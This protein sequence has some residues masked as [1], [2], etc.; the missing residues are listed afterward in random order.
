ME[1]R[2]VI[3]NDFYALDVNA[4]NALLFRSITP[5]AVGRERKN[6][7]KHKTCSYKYSVIF[8][9]QQLFICKRAFCSLYQI[10]RKK[11]DVIKA[12]LKSGKSVPSKDRR[13]THT[14]RPH[15]LGDA[16]EQAI[17]AHINTFPTEE[18]H[19]SRNSNPHKRYLAP[20]LN[21][22]LMYRLYIDECK[23]QNLGENFLVNKSSYA[24]I[25]L[26]KFNLS[27]SHPKSDTC[28]R[29]DAGN[30]NDEHKENVNLGFQL[31]SKDRENAS[32]DEKV[33][34]ITVDLQQTM[35]LPKLTTSKA[36]YLRQI[37][38]YNLGIHV[39]TTEGQ[40][41][42][43][44]TW[45][46]DIAGRGSAEVVSCLWNF[47]QTCENVKTKEQL[48]VWSDSCSGQNKNFHMICFYQLLI[49]KG[50]FKVID[51]KFP[52]VGHTYLDSDRDFG[53]IEKV[54]RKHST[55][56]TPDQYRQIIKS[57]CTKKS[58]VND[59]EQYFR[60]TDGLPN[61]MG[62]VH[63]KK[64]LLNE[65]VPFRDGIKWIRI[66]EFGSYLYKESY[67][68][69]TPYK[70][71]SLFKNPPAQN[72]VPPTDIEFTRIHHKT[73]IISEKKLLTFVSSCLLF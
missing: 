40:K 5:L 16:I 65:K 8:D 41:S 21:M 60:D 2:K 11:V 19:Y 23:E 49:L 61:K 20:N 25:F 15:K 39:V 55:I 70:K 12:K 10:S 30:S 66:E 63:K 42:V 47:V 53:R 27:F 67:D 73:G 1:T 34:Y 56:F 59:M 64:N 18:S 52:E 46:E 72:Y 50:I 69:Y 32:K 31:M 13:G 44:Q 14:N 51:H 6:A 57:A 28:S 29:C 26:N 3:F 54:L 48:T 24:K 9:N 4:K 33:C 68:E 62:L 22:S 43:M 35:P 7:S 17:I 58:T 38:F 37:W 45:T 71:V 36:F